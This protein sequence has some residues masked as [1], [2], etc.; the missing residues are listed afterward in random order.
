MCTTVYT[1]AFALCANLNLD[2]RNRFF[3]T[4][5]ALHTDCVY[6]TDAYKPSFVKILLFDMNANAKPFLNVC[7]AH[8]KKV[9]VYMATRFLKLYVRDMCFPVFLKSFRKFEFYSV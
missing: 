1:L 6:I 9:Y 7:Y 2:A 5:I 3:L 4:A 8:F